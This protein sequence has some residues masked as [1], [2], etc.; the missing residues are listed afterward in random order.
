LGR[1]QQR[2]NSLGRVL[3]VV[4]NNGYV[5]TARMRKT[6]QHGIEFAKIPAQCNKFDIF[7]LIGQVP[8]NLFRPIGTAVVDEHNLESRPGKTHL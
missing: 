6:A 3:K 7:I 8:A 2:Q 1:F 4:V 5:L